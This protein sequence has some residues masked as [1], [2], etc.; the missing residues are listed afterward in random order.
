MIQAIFSGEKISSNSPQAFSLYEKSRFGEK[1]GKK[2]E[3]SLV[4]T[5]LLF[6]EDKLQ[7][8]SNN[9]PLSESNLLKKLKRLDKKI[10]TK[11]T[12]FSDLRK[13]GYVVKTALK[14]GAEFRV[15]NKGVRPGEDHAKWILF[16]T[17]E[18]DKLEWHDFS[19]KNRIAHST[20]K[21]LLLAIVDQESDVTYYEV[22][23]L[24]P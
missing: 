6:Q 3:Y 20:K 10:E 18:S 12:V 16:T 21:K 22:S 23:W 7:V 5:L 13:K 14:F 11:L 9:K 8:I 17:K 2:V 15:Y 4:E 24:K 1:K 19:A